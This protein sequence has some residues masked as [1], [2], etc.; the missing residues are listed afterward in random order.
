MCSSTHLCSHMK[1]RSTRC[2]PPS[3]S[4]YSFEVQSLFEPR[5]CAFSA[6]LEAIKPQF[7]I[8]G[9]TSMQAM[10]T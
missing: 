2:L 10:L 7:P 4:P 6:R 3:L 8:A 5:D 1:S 9:D